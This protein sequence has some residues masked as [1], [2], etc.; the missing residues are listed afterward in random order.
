[1]FSLRE[2]QMTEELGDANKL[3]LYHGTT[4][5]AMENIV[6]FG[7]NRSFT[8]VDGKNSQIYTAGKTL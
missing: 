1:M 4:Q 2:G 3:Y 5:R 6:Q 8:G 7:M